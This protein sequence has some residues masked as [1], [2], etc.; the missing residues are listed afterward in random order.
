MPCPVG[1]HV[2]ER[3]AVKFGVLHQMSQS[4]PVDAE[5]LFA[6]R[7]SAVFRLEVF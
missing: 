6:L 2:S 7:V 1:L 4:F 3:F 5:G